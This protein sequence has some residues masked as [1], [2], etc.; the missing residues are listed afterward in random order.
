MQNTNLG[1][2]GMWCCVMEQTLSCGPPMHGEG[3]PPLLCYF[4]LPLPHYP[5][6]NHSLR[7]GLVWRYQVAWREAAVSAGITW[8][9]RLPDQAPNLQDA[10]C[11]IKTGDS[12]KPQ[13]GW[14][15]VSEISTQG[16]NHDM[17]QP[18]TL[19]KYLVKTNCLS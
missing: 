16:S 18:D 9:G 19:Y 1:R 13:Y 6:S 17:P 14:N 4:P 7:T 5:S 8:I 2:Y 12:F 3:M 11:P 15:T 10:G